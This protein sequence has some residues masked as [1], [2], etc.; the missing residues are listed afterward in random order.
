MIRRPT[1]SSPSRRTI[2]GTSSSTQFT[3]PTYPGEAYNYNVD[4]NND[5]TYEATAQTGSYTCSYAAAG[6]YTVRIQDNTGLGTGF[7]RFYAN[8]SGDAQKLLTIAQ[9]GTGKWTS[10]NS[11]FKGCNALTMTATDQPDLS[12]VTDMSY[13]FANATL[14]NGAIGGW[15]TSHVTNMSHLLFTAMAFNQP[16]GSWNTS[17]VTSMEYMLAN[18]WS[19]NQDIHTW[20]TSKVTNMH[21]MLAS[22]SAFNQSLN[23]WDTGSVTNMVDMF[24]GATAFNGSIGL[25]DTHSVTSMQTMFQMARAF[26]QDIS[27]WN[28]ANVTSMGGMFSY[29]DAFNQNIGSW[30]T[31][32][33]T[34][35]SGM[36]AMPRP[37]TRTFTPGTPAR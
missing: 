27:S 24:V 10:M 36:L 29:T 8:Q 33:V 22:A 18:T 3:I 25:W 35:M 23:G 31:A 21:G 26:N 19:F 9:W 11:A 14:F 34:D 17:N 15:D 32:K 13:M 5:G 37:S 30:N 2:P 20:D 4:C 28:T 1:S 12:G 16:I 6:T 7:P